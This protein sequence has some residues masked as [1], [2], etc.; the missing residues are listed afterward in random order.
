MGIGVM[1]FAQR[2]AQ[3]SR[4]RWSSSDLNG[5]ISSKLSLQ[6]SIFPLIPHVHSLLSDSWRNPGKP[7]SNFEGKPY[8]FADTAI[9]F[10]NVMAWKMTEVR[11]SPSFEAGNCSYDKICSNGLIL[12]WAWML[13]N[14]R[15]CADTNGHNFWNTEIVQAFLHVFADKGL[16]FA[17]V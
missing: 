12:I 6:N 15:T 4:V 7:C 1:L 5:V 9:E 8:L 17:P 2:S 16:H 3:T 10:N 11:N 14:A 13:G